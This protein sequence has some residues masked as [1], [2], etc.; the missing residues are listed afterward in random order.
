MRTADS[1]NRHVDM[2][3]YAL[4][5]IVVISSTP[6]LASTHAHLIR[7]TPQDGSEVSGPVTTIILSFTEALEPKLINIAVLAD[8]KPISELGAATLG[9][10]GRTAKMAV[11][12]LMHNTYTVNWNVVSIDG[13]RTDGKFRFFVRGP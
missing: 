13:H 5:L 1:W 10:D 3:K 7:S 6:D 2:N 11:P 9:N 8:E 12:P 4:V